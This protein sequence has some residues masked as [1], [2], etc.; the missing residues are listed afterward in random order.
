[1]AIL[2]K[3]NMKEFKMLAVNGQLGYGFPEDIFMN[4]MQKKPDI[5]GADGGSNDGGPFYLGAGLSHCDNDAIKR[6]LNIIIPAIRE[7]NVPFVI[8]SAST[9]GG[10][11]HVDVTLDIVKRICKEI[12]WKAK[13]A[14]IRSEVPKELVLKKWRI[15]EISPIDGAPE[16]SEQDINSSERIVAQIGTEPFNRALETEADIIVAGRACDTAIFAA[17]P[18]K[19]GFDPALCFHAAKIL[20]CGA[21]CCSPGVSSESMM[22]VIRENDFILETLNP[23]RKVLPM[24][25]SAHSLYEQGHPSKFYEPDGMTECGSAAFEAY[26]GSDRAVRVFGT[27]FIANLNGKLTLKLEGVAKEGYRTA[28]IV[29][30]RDIYMIKNLDI[31]LDNVRNFIK[32]NMGETQKGLYDIQFH[33]Y[34]KNAV[35]GELEYVKNTPHEVGVLID[36][37]AED[38]ILANTVCAL[39]RSNI[40]HVEYPERRTTGGNVAMAFSPHDIPVGAVYRFSIYH[41]LENLCNKDFESMFPIETAE[42]Y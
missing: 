7:A 34:G 15:G 13:I 33:V 10:N 6:D 40:L 30:I 21:Y 5:V 26:N 42:A 27:K 37:L 36:V 2:G 16:L 38:Q 1:M 9:A 8:G 14:V 12:S 24:S 3:L 20:E 35:M 11:P 19:M 29:G 22:A 32:K 4:G 31:A 28:C 41:I 18:I 17:L 39:A 23:R 25:V